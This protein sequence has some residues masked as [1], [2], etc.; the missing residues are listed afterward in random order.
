MKRIQ[1][2]NYFE[3]IEACWPL[4]NL[5]W[6][7]NPLL[8]TL[9]IPVYEFLLLPCL[10]K[11]VPRTLRRIGLAVVLLLLGIVSLFVLD[12]TGGLENF[13]TC[14]TN[15]NTTNTIINSTNIVL[16]LI[17]VSLLTLA[18]MLGNIAGMININIKC[19]H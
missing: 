19:M 16:V 7:V 12:L 2:S 9:L 1:K 6:I 3:E 10:Q 15:I 14:N 18:E 13:S 5:Y 8:I 17:P 4:D 11:Y